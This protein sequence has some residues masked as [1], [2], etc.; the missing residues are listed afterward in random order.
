MFCF[1]GRQNLIVRFVVLRL[2]IAF[3]ISRCIYYQPIGGK[4]K[5]RALRYQTMGGKIEA[6]HTFFGHVFPL[7]AP[8]AWVRFESFLDWL[9]LFSVAD[10]IGQ[11]YCFGFGFAPLK[12]KYALS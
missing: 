12:F 4:G 11:K 6:H 9:I 1:I 3:K 2:K 8:V 7:F 5:N 10:V